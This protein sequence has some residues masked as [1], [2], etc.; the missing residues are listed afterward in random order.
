MLV[1]PDLGRQ[2]QV[3]AWGCGYLPD[4]LACELCSGIV[5]DAVSRERVEAFNESYLGLLRLLH[6]CTHEHTYRSTQRSCSNEREAVIV[7]LESHLGVS[8]RY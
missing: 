3:D 8:K 6:A 7:D 5:R 4:I 2:T 1:I